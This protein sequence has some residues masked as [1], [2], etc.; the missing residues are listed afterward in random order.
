MKQTILILGTI[1]GL[2]SCSKQSSSTN[3]SSPTNTTVGEQTSSSSQVA[4]LALYS[5]SSKNLTKYAFVYDANGNLVRLSYN[6]YDTTGG[7]AALDSGSYYFTI[8]PSTQLASSYT[9][10]WNNANT[11]TASE[12]HQLFFD[13]QKRLIKDT[14]VTGQAQTGH[15]TTFYFSYPA[16]GVVSNGYAMNAYDSL[17]KTY[18]W[19]LSGIDSISLVNGNIGSQ[20]EY[21]QNGVSWVMGY[22]YV[23]KNYSSDP[24]PLHG[25]DQSSGLGTLLRNYNS[26]D[27]ISKDLPSDGM[28][29][30]TTD[31]N[32]R[33]SGGLATDGSITT[34]TYK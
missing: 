31:A 2:F 1:L 24:N 3:Q 25:L 17:N 11:G 6:S 23:V 16:G 4:S 28:A 27:C 10:V 29:N 30:W 5:P 7:I 19:G 9:L 21:A 22:S 18:G 13:D 33:V 20:Y 12:T 32:G 14:L 34:Y 26:L 8:D 15:N